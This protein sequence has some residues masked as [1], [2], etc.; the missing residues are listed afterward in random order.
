MVGTPAFQQVWQAEVH[1]WGSVV[2][3]GGWV[4][5]VIVRTA[6]AALVVMVVSAD[7]VLNAGMCVYL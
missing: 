2:G 6:A 1:A 3:G 4:C 7:C 5:I